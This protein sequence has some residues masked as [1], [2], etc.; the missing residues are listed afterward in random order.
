MARA[1][2]EHQALADRYQAEIVEFRQLLPTS[3]LLQRKARSIIYRLQRR[4]LTVYPL[5]M[6]LPRA[7]DRI[8]RGTRLREV[9]IANLYPVAQARHAFYR[10]LVRH[11]RPDRVLLSD[12]RDVLFQTDPFVAIQD[13]RSLHVFAEDPRVSLGAC[14][15]N[16]KWLASAYGLPEVEALAGRTI[17]CAGVTFGSAAAVEAYL[18]TMIDELSRIRASHSGTD[19]ACHNVIVYDDQLAVRVHENVEGPIYTM[20]N[21]P[22]EDLRWNDQGLLVNGLGEPYAVLHQYD[23]LEGVGLQVTDAHAVRQPAG[24]THT[25]A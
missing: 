7:L 22:P 23:R 20:G 24:L 25:P 3:P 13:S 5:L 12:L 1:K 16:S 17:I 15:H 10:A 6:A 21:V 8:G 11:R 9:A 2:A 4:G 19:Q 18:V 14:P